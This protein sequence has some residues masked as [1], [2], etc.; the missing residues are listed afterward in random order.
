MGRRTGRRRGCGWARTGWRPAVGA[1]MVTLAV[2]R[3]GRRAGNR[4]WSSDTPRWR[5]KSPRGRIGCPRLLRELRPTEAAELVITVGI[6]GAAGQGT[7]RPTRGGTAL[8][9]VGPATH[10]GRWSAPALGAEPRSRGSRLGGSRLGARCSRLEEL[11]AADRVAT[12][13]R[14]NAAKG[15]KLA[16]RSGR[17]AR[18]R[19]TL[20]LGLGSSATRPGR[21]APLGRPQPAVALSIGRPGSPSMLSAF[22]SRQY[23]GK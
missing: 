3:W 21:R 22:F 9:S 4:W 1:R 10:A 8:A 11:G 18:S 6:P 19:L 17:S 16:T 23:R 14:F 13:V 5:S 2:G 12:F 15:T 7:N 20:S